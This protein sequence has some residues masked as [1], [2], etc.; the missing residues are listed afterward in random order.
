LNAS[1]SGVAPTIWIVAGSW[2][3]LLAW[4]GLLWTAVRR[5]VFRRETGKLP[6][7]PGR[8]VVECLAAF[9]FVSVAVGVAYQLRVG[10]QTEIPAAD[11]LG[12]MA[13]I[14]A[15]LVVIVP[16]IIE[17]RSGLTL[18]DLGLVHR[19]ILVDDTVSGGLLCLVLLPLVYAV[20]TGAQ[21]IWPAH[22]HSVQRAVR[23]QFSTEMAA[24][25]VLS[26]VILAPIAEELFFRGVLLGWLQT[27]MTEAAGHAVGPMWLLGIWLPNVLVSILFAAIHWTEWPAPLALFVLSLGLGWLVQRSGRL[28]GAI[29]AHM[30]FNGL[31]TVLLFLSTPNATPEAEPAPPPAAQGE[32]AAATT[33]IR[34]PGLPD[35]WTMRPILRRIPADCL[36]P[37]RGDLGSA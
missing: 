6:V 2:L 4:S 21:L 19:R 11:Q 23:E 29:A 28:G 12:L 25:V 34:P 1:T 18:S 36:T 24:L 31:S 33:G 27:R 22:E 5:G 32:P 9:A 16:W 3:A 14:N 35:S 15:L 30:L 17:K 20:F 7:W 13:V 10:K 26:A 37:G 8:A